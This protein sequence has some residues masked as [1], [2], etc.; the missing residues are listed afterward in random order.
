L[1]SRYNRTPT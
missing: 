1:K